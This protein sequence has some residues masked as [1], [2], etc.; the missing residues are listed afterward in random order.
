MRAVTPHTNTHK[1]DA[2]INVMIYG[3]IHCPQTDNYINDMLSYPLL[4]NDK[5]VCLIES[6]HVDATQ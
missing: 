5:E 6:C 4:V 3:T 1:L 2:C